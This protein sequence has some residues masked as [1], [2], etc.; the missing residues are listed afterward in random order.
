MRLE[1]V[2]T[3][4]G[5]A[6]IRLPELD[7]HYHSFHGA[8]QEA[9]HVFIRNGLQSRE[10]NEIAVFEL[11]FGT[12]L[13]ALLTLKYA[14][15]HKKRIDY[16]GLEA[17]PLGM[18]LID[19]LNYSDLIGKEFEIDFKTM[20]L[21]EWN[22]ASQIN[23]NFTLRKEHGR[24]EEFNPELLAG[25]FDLIYFDAFGFRAQPEMWGLAILEKMHFLLKKD[26][27]LVTYAA[28]GQFKRDLKSLGFEVESCP[29]PPGKREMTRAIKK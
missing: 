29:G 20:H 4:D 27:L 6:T 26:G 24:V 17:F 16:F 15:A 18:D 11:G 3:E 1:I 23:D 22:S 10:G 5:S 25:S 28:R 13:N 12:G 14:L 7:E 19:Q 21:A 2:K 9:E 8:L